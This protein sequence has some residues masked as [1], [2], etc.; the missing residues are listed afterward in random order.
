[1]AFGFYFVPG[2]LDFAIWADQESAADDSFE[3]TA[4]EFFRAPGAEGFNHFVG[5][6]AKKREIQFLLGFETLQRFHGIGAG[7]KN[8]DAELVEFWLCVTKLGRFSRST[9]SVGL[10]KEKDQDAL[11]F[12]VIEGDFVALIG[13]EGEIGGFVAGLEHGMNLAE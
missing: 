11:A 5:R 13:S 10:R 7:A 1:V 12:E 4:H 6:I 2:F 9:G 3:G 8:G